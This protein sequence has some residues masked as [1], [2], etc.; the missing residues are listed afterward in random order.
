MRPYG[1]TLLVRNT[2]ST[3]I[4]RGYACGLIGATCR[5]TGFY[6]G[7]CRK[8][9]VASNTALW[10]VRIAITR[11]RLVC[12]SVH[13][14]VTSMC[15]NGGTLS[16]S[17]TLS[18][19]I[20]RGHAF[21]LIGATCRVA[22]LYGGMCRKDCITTDTALWGVRVAIT[23]E[24]FA[25]DP[26]VA[27]LC[28][29]CR[30]QSSVIDLCIANG[31]GPPSATCPLSKSHGPGTCES[32]F[33]RARLCQ[34]SVHVDFHR[35]SFINECNV[36]VHIE[37]ASG[38]TAAI[39]GVEAHVVLPVPHDEV[40]PLVRASFVSS[41]DGVITRSISCPLDPR[42]CRELVRLN[43]KAGRRANAN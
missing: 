4:G 14:P 5:E 40:K 2:L 34:F 7:V 22:V 28:D 38:W 11:E 13:S 19:S 37:R 1:R 12:G 26:D 17:N 43:P 15:L 24:R 9:R 16:V 32:V 36:L 18:T 20:R 39:V 27:S 35:S 21:R 29:F 42:H 30:G 33:V 6:S 10:G 23:L 8:D 31:T 25:S 3:S 41:E